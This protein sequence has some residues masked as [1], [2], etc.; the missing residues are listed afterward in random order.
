MIN[1]LAVRYFFD[2]Y[3][4]NS[5]GLTIHLD[6]HYLK[7][8]P[9]PKIPQSAQQPF[10]ALVDKII[11]AKKDGTDTQTLE[12]KIDKLVYK[13]YNLT[14]DEIKIIEISQ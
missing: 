10:I 8:I 9:I 13:L 12:T 7:K 6:G 3:I 2:R 14:V 5:A 1:S 4:V 11:Q